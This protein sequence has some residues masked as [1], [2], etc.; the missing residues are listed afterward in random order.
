MPKM[1]IEN[2]EINSGEPCIVNS[3]D[4]PGYEATKC[5]DQEHFSFESE[6]V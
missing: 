1:F 5:Q 3:E 4:K 2:Q 6:S